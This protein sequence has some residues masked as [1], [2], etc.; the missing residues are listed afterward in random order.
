[1]HV[2][3]D[4][5]IDSALKT[6]MTTYYRIATVLRL[7][8]PSDLCDNGRR[9]TDQARNRMDAAIRRL[10]GHGM[11]KERLQV[12]ALCDRI[13]ILLMKFAEVQDIGAPLLKYL[14]KCKDAYAQDAVKEKLKPFKDSFH[15]IRLI[16]IDPQE[17][18]V[19]RKLL[20]M[21]DALIDRGGK[22]HN[23]VAK[24]S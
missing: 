20:A 12:K 22:Y 8:F 11:P 17:Q 5:N 9:L 14:E 6:D 15:A 7:C 1:M 24:M 18:S 3:E 10:V 16:S 21:Y 2:Y 19:H 23:S 4:W 13:D